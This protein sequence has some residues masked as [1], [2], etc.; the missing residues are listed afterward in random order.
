MKEAKASAIP[1]SRRWSV[2]QARGVLEALEQSGLPVTRFAAR[3]G[4]GAE[5]LY[6]WRRRL[7]LEK[8]TK[9]R[10]PRFT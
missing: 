5:R 3:H 10:P 4:L 6:Q 8:N 2:A 7:G 9:S 1:K